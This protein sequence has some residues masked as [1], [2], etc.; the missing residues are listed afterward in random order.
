MHLFDC[1][2]VGRLLRD[3]L[4]QVAAEVVQPNLEPEQ[5]SFEDSCKI[6]ESLQY[7]HSQKYQSLD[8]SVNGYVCS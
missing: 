7:G 1:G 5:T 8:E 3:G 4:E 2:L 6:T